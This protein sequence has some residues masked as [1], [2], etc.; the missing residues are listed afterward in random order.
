MLRYCTGLLLSPLYLTVWAGLLLVFHVLQWAALYSRGESARRR[1]A[2]ALN[3][4]LLHCIWLLGIR[5]VLIYKEKP[6]TDKPLIIVAN[7]QNQ[8]DISGISWLFRQQDPVFV[9][10]IELGRGLPSISYNLR[11]SGAALIDRQDPRQS[12]REIA[13][14]GKLIQQET[15]A[16]VIFPEGTRARDGQLQLFATAGV[17]MLLKNAPDA[18]VIPVAIDGAWRMGSLRHFPLGTIFQIR[19]TVLPALPAATAEQLVAQAE[20]AIRRE[21]GQG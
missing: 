15:R 9:S 18:V 7:H 1:M 14:L 6:P 11:H 13:R 5:P 12:L 2:S 19:W 10:K 21:L 17:K 20:T 4:C 3:W 16:A 8:I